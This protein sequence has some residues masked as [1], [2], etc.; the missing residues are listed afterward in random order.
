MLIESDK[1][2]LAKYWESLKHDFFLA[3]KNLK[4]LL[5]INTP[6]SSTGT[7]IKHQQRHKKMRALLVAIL[8]PLI[9]YILKMYVFFALDKLWVW[10]IVSLVLGILVYFLTLWVLYFQ[11]TI[12]TLSTILLL[13]A[14]FTFIYS[15]F[16]SYL[17]IERVTRVSLLGSFI[18]F[19]LAFVGFLYTALLTTNILNVNTFYKIPLANLAQSFLVVLEVVLIS[20]WTFDLYRYAYDISVLDMRILSYRVFF[21]G[22]LLV[23]AVVL[24]AIFW[25]FWSHLYKDTKK[26]FVLSV[27]M[28]IIVGL[29]VIFLIFVVPNV[30]KIALFIA[31]FVYMI[32]GYMLHVI[33]KTFDWESWIEFA[34]IFVILFAII[35]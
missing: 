16:V 29:L 30:Y 34:V 12:K 13:P 10:F 25:V 15:W 22:V 7:N 14:L 4:I 5:G 24:F 31:L 35:I 17:F 2:N 27:Y 28:S 6:V 26:A 18:V 11:V 1:K 8:I 20:I 19:L 9:L 3:T 33:H 32:L 21:L 23:W